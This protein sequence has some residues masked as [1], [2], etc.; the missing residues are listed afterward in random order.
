[1]KQ[2]KYNYTFYFFSVLLV[3]LLLAL[4]LLLIVS[5]NRYNAQKES[6]I[7][8]Y[9][10][11]LDLR[12][13]KIDFILENIVSDLLILSEFDIFIDFLNTESEE[14]RKSVEQIFKLICTERGTYDQIRFI[15]TDGMEKIRINYNQGNPV[16][17]YKEDLQ[18]K[19]NRYYFQ[20]TF[21]L[22]RGEVFFSPLDLNVE[23]GVVEIPKKPIIRVGIPVFNTDGTKKGII[24]VNYFGKNILDIAAQPY[25][26]P[27]EKFFLLNSEGFYLSSPDQD[28]NFG[29]M[30]RDSEELKFQS[31]NR[32]V[33]SEIKGSDNGVVQDKGS[34]YIYKTI[35]PL[36][37][38]MR[39]SSGSSTPAGS[40]N[41][42]KA[43]DYYW[44]L[45]V[46]LP[47]TI[48]GTLIR[49]TFYSML[50]LII[51]SIA[52]SLLWSFIIAKLWFFQVESEKRTKEA[53]LDKELLLR[54]IHHRVKNSL[55]LVSSFIGLYQ[56]ENPDHCYDSFFDTLQQKIE[57]IALVHTHLY[58]SRDIE[59]ISIKKYVTD[60][61][62]NE[63]GNL[64]VSEGKINLI[65][66][67]EDLFLKPRQTI[68][69]GLIISELAVNSLKHAFPGDRRGDI[70]VS[71]RKKMGD[72]EIVFSD[73]GIGL[74]E[75][76]E[77]NNTNSLGMVIIGTLVNQLEGSLSIKTGSN[78]SFIIRFPGS[79]SQNS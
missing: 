18:F 72:I 76:F 33:W 42:V 19:G 17:V 47:D 49:S 3:T 58:Q 70:K 39:T 15:D 74:P 51:V 69:I 61:L 9:Q 60:L 8:V 4:T 11:Q 21:R 57:S 53:L 68:N 7:S 2:E 5:F 29:F 35:Y 64:E 23:N 63:L 46:C 48:F 14:S 22:T 79:E 13:N 30:Y 10:D 43:E 65:I 44:K 36:K 32:S 50:F 59:N 37:D 27:L 12:Y 31:Y 40:S 77:K 34:F 16:I 71:L 66:N 28:K 26:Y 20:D 67:M 25:K 41:I 24:I 62:E 45:V 1:M 73:N 6:V 52:A 56:S 55:S 54:E 78:S 75:N 38:Y